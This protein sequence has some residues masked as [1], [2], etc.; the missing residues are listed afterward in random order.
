MRRLIMNAHAFRWVVAGCLAVAV[1]AS[2]VRAGQQSPG[3]PRE[4]TVAISAI[5][6]EDKPVTDLKVSEV[7]V[8]EDNREREVRRV[9]PAPPPTHVALLIDDSQVTKDAMLFLRT[10]LKGFV[11]RMMSGEQA[12]QIGLWTF[13]ERPTRRADF[14]PNSA[15]VERAIDRTFALQGSGSYLLEAI[16]EVSKDLRKRKAERPVIVAFV[17]ERGPEFSSLLHTNVA[18]TLKNAGASLW[19]ITQQARNQ[20]MGVPELRERAMVLGDVTGW[21]GGANTI[22]LTPQ[23][24][25]NAFASLADQML[26]RM[27]VTYVRPEALVPPERIQVTV[28][29]PEVKVRA[30]RWTGR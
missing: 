12:P 29:R 5:G 19:T 11:K 8:R 7:T 2:G 26:G 4:R 18:D 27:A 13:G 16:D 21:S 15:Q 28:K 22:V 1:S 10:A 20:N 3:D 17:D 25:D 24:L 9:E 23:A 30:P 6:P 14:S